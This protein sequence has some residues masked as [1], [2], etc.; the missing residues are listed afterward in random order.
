MPAEPV[1]VE[2]PKHPLHAL[3]TFELKEYR[4]QL[5]G[6]IAF[7]EAKDPV[8]P[9]RNRLRATLDTVIAE[10]DERAKIAHAR[11]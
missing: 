1:I 8:P 5:E 6:A 4:R 2:P 11:A 9:C 7:F 3:T 10:Q